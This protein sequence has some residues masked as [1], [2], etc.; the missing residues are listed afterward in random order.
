LS[1]LPTPDLNLVSHWRNYNAANYSINYPPNLLPPQDIGGC[2]HL[3]DLPDPQSSPSSIL[4]DHTWIVMCWQTSDM[5]TTN[6]PDSS[7]NNIA[8]SQTFTLNSYMGQMGYKG[9]RFD[10]SLGPVQ[11]VY[12]SHPY[13]GYLELQLNVGNLSDFGQI[14]SSI[15]FLETNHGHIK[16]QNGNVYYISSFGQNILANKDDFTQTEYVPPIIFTD[17]QLSPDQDKVLLFAQGGIT[18]K[19]LFYTKVNPI[20]VKYIH[21]VSQALWSPSSRYIVYTSHIADAGGDYFL[22]VYDTETNRNLVLS[23]KSSYSN[24][25]IY[26]LKSWENNNTGILVHYQTQSDIPY[27]EIIKEGDVVIPLTQF[28]PE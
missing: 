14:V 20:L 23:P 15:K 21:T 11:T 22:G 17:A 6:S 2:T 1:P 18:S 13:G 9:P 25:N 7:S 8:M 19:Q 28:V 24:T 10:T 5:P 16:I 27:G 12:L 4:K 3:S 26:T